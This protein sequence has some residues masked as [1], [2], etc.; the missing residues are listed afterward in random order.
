MVK[1]SSIQN[2]NVYPYSRV[3]KIIILSIKESSDF[4]LDSILIIV[5]FNVYFT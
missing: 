3:K 1:F 4:L 2:R 5:I